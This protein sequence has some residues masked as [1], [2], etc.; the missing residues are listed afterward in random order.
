[1][2]MLVTFLIPGIAFGLSAGLSPGPLL[3]LVITETLKHGIRAGV[4][5]AIAPLLTDLPIVGVTLLLLSQLSDAKP[6][7][8]VISLIGGIFLLYL[9]VESFTFKGIGADISN[10]RPRSYQKGILAN[11]LNPSPY[12]FWLSIGGPL[13][14]K[15]FEQ[16]ILPVF[17]FV[18][19]FYLLLV[20]S[21]VVLAVMVGKSR[22]FLKS[23]IY[24]HTVRVLGIVLVGF[25][26]LFLREGLAYLGIL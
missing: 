16:G 6:V 24:V 25:S 26:C 14:I 20:G 5:V 10:T 9:G 18:A 2:T 15:A 19:G 8:G 23:G 7:L 1:M 3:T 13:M 12:L 22:K 11:F 4:R 17:S 21:K